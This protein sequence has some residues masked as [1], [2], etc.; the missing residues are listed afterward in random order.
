MGLGDSKEF[1][2]ISD[3]LGEVIRNGDETV[4]R[5]PISLMD[6]LPKQKSSYFRYFGSVTTPTCNEIVTWTVFDNFFEIS[7]K[8]ASHKFILNVSFTNNNN[9]KK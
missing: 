6:M 3:Q 4:L 1:M 9:L 5:K 7:E 2:P 8:Q